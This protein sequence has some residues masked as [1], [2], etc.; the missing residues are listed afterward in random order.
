MI[1]KYF[2][3]AWVLALNLLL[4]SSCLN[5]S[6]EEIEYSTDAQIY[7]FSL[8]SATDTTNVL[9]NTKFT[10]D[11]INGKI[12][13]KEPLPYMFDVD[14]VVLKISGSSTY[15]L[16][17]EVKLTL[18]P[19]STYNW[20][21]TDSVAI[22]RLKRITTTAPDGVTEK[23][24][25]FELRIHQEDPYIL[26]WQQLN[27]AYLSFP[28]DSQ[29]TIAFKN[30]F[31]TYLKS[32]SS[33]KV[34]HS[35]GTNPTT[36]NTIGLPHTLT[37]SSLLSTQDTMF[38]LDSSAGTVYQ[39]TDGVTW[40]QV[41]TP[42]TVKAIYGELP[43]ATSGAILVAAEVDGE[44]SFAQTD[45][46][47]VMTN[48]NKVPTN[49]PVKD[50]SVT[51]VDVP[52]VYSKYL[53]VAGGT[54]AKNATT[55]AAWILLENNGSI[56]HILARIPSSVSLTG[57]SLFFYDEKPYLMF[58]ASGKNKLMYSENF[59][60]DWIEAAENQLFPTNFSQRSFASVITDADNYIW[61]F[62]G[63]SN[64]QTQLTDLWR[65]KLNKFYSY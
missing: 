17:Y 14:S 6:S 3:L 1:S 55:N 39:S 9:S 49:M 4:F 19:D 44:L 11:Q 5:S 36:V 16:F 63:I 58:S 15:T 8:S 59:G 29:K 40:S 13:N 20:I 31:F 21:D 35:N 23:R 45:D 7:A 47:T 56:N 50:F 60:L 26:S 28:F 12:F 30:R 42:Y 32:G 33:I 37:L 48:L 51:T 53:I 2:S 64:A 43:L 46:F 22:N 24:Y 27:P 61:I 38:G 10:I 52:N 18:E 54:T 62:G 34:L 57:S 41:N 65:G 25:D